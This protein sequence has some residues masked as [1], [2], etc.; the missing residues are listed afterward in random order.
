MRERRKK[1]KNALKTFAV[2]FITRKNKIT[3]ERGSR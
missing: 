1:K 2:L 3:V